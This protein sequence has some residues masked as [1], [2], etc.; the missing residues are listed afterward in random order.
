LNT[1]QREI[2]LRW[3]LSLHARLNNL[4]IQINDWLDRLETQGYLE[5]IELAKSLEELEQFEDRVVEIVW[6]ES[7]PTFHNAAEGSRLPPI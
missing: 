7:W 1:L 3:G 5:R 6:Q 2:G 4:E